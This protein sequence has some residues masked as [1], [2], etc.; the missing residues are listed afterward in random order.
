MYQI[1]LLFRPPTGIVQKGDTIV[2]S[3]TIWNYNEN[4]E[5]TLKS[6]NFRGENKVN[7]PIKPANS[8][9]YKNVLPI[10]IAAK[11]K[12]VYNIS[13]TGHDFGSNKIL[14]V[15]NFNNGR[16]DFEVCKTIIYINFFTT[17][18]KI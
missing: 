6:V 12:A 16:E 4:S 8:K 1:K 15:F 17:I 10:K 2:H 9:I 7:K 18:L 13:C 5:I 3:I 14:V 11:S